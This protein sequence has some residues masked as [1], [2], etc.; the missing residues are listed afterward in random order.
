MS[1]PG[2]RSANRPQLRV[3]ARRVGPRK[4]T[5]ATDRKLVL[6]I[7]VRP[8]GLTVLPGHFARSARLPGLHG[9]VDGPSAL[10]FTRAI[11]TGLTPRMTALEMAECNIEVG[12]LARERELGPVD[13]Q[14]RSPDPVRP[15]IRDVVRQQRGWTGEEPGH[16]A[17]GGRTKPAHHDSRKGRQWRPKRS[18]RTDEQTA[19]H[20]HTGDTREYGRCGIHV[21]HD[22]DDRPTGAPQRSCGF[23]ADPS[24]GAGDDR[25]TGHGRGN[26]TGFPEVGGLVGNPTPICDTS[27]APRSFVFRGPC[28]RQFPPGECGYG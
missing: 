1:H 28:R 14:D 4:R 17:R 27:S 16:R 20:G 10:S 13:G 8:R 18:I 21:P 11:M 2:G 6:L 22:G 5:R 9:S 7:V 19:T 23:C 3:A 12:R 15:R 24:T 25:S 26:L